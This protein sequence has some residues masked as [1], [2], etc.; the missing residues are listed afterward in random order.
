LSYSR[1][2]FRQSG[3]P[4]PKYIVGFFEK[5]IGNGTQGNE[6]GNLYGLSGFHRSLLEISE[7]GMLASPKEIFP[8]HIGRAIY[9]VPPAVTAAVIGKFLSTQ[10]P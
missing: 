6:I 7:M 1:P 9:F 10:L 3:V 4:F 5:H 8:F 2:A